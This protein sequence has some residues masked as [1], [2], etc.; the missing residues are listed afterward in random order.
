MDA[1]IEIASFR[2][3]E[4]EVRWIYLNDDDWAAYDEEIRKD[5]PSAV[6]SFSYRDV[7][8]RRAAR[9]SCVITNRGCCVLVP[10]RLSPR[11]KKAA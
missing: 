10:K 1:A 9:R 8:I 2:Y 7:Q 6:R 11:V 5:W 3:P 4:S